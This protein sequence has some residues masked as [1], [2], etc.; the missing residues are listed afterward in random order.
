MLLLVEL[1]GSKLQRRERFGAGFGREAPGGAPWEHLDATEA[2]RHQG[3]CSREAGD[4]VQFASMVA[5]MERKP[6]GL[7]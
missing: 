2:A 4:K 3:K 5:L 6:G 1:S 7:G